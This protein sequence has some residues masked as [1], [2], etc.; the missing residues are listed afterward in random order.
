M[1]SFKVFVVQTTKQKV[2]AQALVYQM[3]LLQHIKLV[4]RFEQLVFILLFLLQTMNQFL[5]LSANAKF[6]SKYLD[7]ER[8]QKLEL[9]MEENCPES[10]NTTLHLH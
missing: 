2:T 7:S 4:S 6:A 10:T 1:Q 9:K 8:T 5:S 3:Y